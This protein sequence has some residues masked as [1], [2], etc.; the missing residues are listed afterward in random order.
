MRRAQRG[1]T[2][3]GFILLLVLAACIAYLAMRLIP[4]YTEYYSVVTALKR[5]AS[6][7]GVET[8]DP[9]RIHNL[10]GR[11]FNISYVDSI[12]HKDVKIVKDTNGMRFVVD[13][14]VRKPVVYNIDLVMHFQKTV[15]VGGKTMNGI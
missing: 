6:E 12:D 10:I 13:Y 8:M 3:I 4:A 15:E 7:P 1:I 11:G 9:D 14:E 5:V 2:F